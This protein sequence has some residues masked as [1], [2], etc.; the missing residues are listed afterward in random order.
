MVR[1]WD[2]AVAAAPRKL[3][4]HTCGVLAVAVSA[5]ARTA[6]SGGDDGT[7]WVW[8]WLTTGSRPAG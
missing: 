6:V 4:G 1:V 5:D 3:T 8:T 7:V 2:L